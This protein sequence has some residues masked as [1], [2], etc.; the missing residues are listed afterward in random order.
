MIAAT[1]LVLNKAPNN[2]NS[3]RSFSMATTSSLKVAHLCKKAKRMKRVKRVMVFHVQKSDLQS[4][5]F[6]VSHPH[7][8]MASA[9]LPSR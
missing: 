8:D 6:A 9:C 7:L 4:Q 3:N 1:P 5:F 2:N